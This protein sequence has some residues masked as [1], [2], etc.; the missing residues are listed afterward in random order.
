MKSE[1]VLTALLIFFLADLF[2]TFIPLTAAT[3]TA[4]IAA[5]V[6]TPFKNE[7]TDL[8]KLI[9]LSYCVCISL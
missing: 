4:P 7:E 5:P 9:I 6:P 3:V 2:E 8:D 1:A